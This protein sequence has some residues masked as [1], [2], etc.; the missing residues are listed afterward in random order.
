MKFDIRTASTEDIIA[1]S[2]RMAR[3]AIVTGE[4][5]RSFNRR[6]RLKYGYPR[7]YLI[8]GNCPHVKGLMDVKYHKRR[9]PVPPKKEMSIPIRELAPLDMQPFSSSRKSVD[10]LLKEHNHIWT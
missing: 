7:L 8:R 9:Q 5:N 6:I 2:H 10:E 3:K 1:K 4:S